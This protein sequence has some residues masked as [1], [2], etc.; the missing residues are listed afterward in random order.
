MLEITPTLDNSR[1]E[2]I[3]IQLYDY[4]RNEIQGGKACYL[5]KEKLTEHLKMS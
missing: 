2:P 3:Y 1:K 5:P 4:I